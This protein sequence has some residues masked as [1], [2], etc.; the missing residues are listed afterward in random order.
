MSDLDDWIVDSRPIE[1]LGEDVVNRIA[2]GE[3]GI[4]YIRLT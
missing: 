3:V 1:R 2:A 4:V